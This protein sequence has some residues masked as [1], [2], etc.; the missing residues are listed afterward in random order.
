MQKE[1]PWKYI[2]KENEQFLFMH[3]P[4]TAGTTFRKI[5]TKHFRQEDIY[6]TEL[7]LFTTKNKYLRQPIL[8]ENRKDLLRKKLICGHYNVRLLPHLSP[9]VK[10]MI[11]LRDPMERIQSHIKHLINKDPEFGQGDPNQV[12][13][14]RLEILCNLQ[15]RI[16]GF[17]KNRPNLDL[18]LQNLEAIN[19]VGI[20]EKF[21]T[22]IEK[23]NEKFAWQ[24][25]YQGER[26]NPS[27]TNFKIPI[28][29]ENIDRIIEK[30]Q[31]ERLLY[32]RACE[33][34]EE[35]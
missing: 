7:H 24:L 23:L 3:V 22:S 1:S 26:L 25:A 6:P 15:A 19:F 11:F 33:I 14:E 10:T 31:P 9:N 29:S 17:T 28:H 30:N 8:I 18:V 27:P 16:L 34:F 20:Q 13:E 5:L 35:K 4:K 21:A 2:P 12:I 32:K